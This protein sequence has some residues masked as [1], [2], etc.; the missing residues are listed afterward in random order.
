MQR[1]HKIWLKY[2]DF[3]ELEEDTQENLLKLFELLF[4][5]VLHISLL[6]VS[7]H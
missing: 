7:F 1:R 3:T 5:Q 4:F 2:T 6:F